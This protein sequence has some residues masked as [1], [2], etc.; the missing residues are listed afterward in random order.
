MDTIPDD[1]TGLAIKRW[2]AEGSDLTKPMKIDFFVSIPNHQV[3]HAFE[4]ASELDGFALS[5][6][7]DSETG[8]WTCYCTKVLVPKNKAALS[9]KDARQIADEVTFANRSVP[10]KTAELY[11]RPGTVIDSATQKLID[12]GELVQKFLPNIADDG[13]KMLSPWQAGGIGAGA[14]GLQRM[15]DGVLNGG[16]YSSGGAVPFKLGK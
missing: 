7:A 16:P 5:T 11:T 14:S 13:F 15:I 3:G 8:K 10:P 12:S 1:D 9:A 4:Q 6:E 2:A